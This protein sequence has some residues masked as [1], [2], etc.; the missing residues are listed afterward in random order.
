MSYTTQQL[1]RRYIKSLLLEFQTDEDDYR[2]VS[3]S[4]LQ[5]QLPTE[6]N[7][8]KYN[9]LMYT[10]DVDFCSENLDNILDTMIGNKDRQQVIRWMRRLEGDSNKILIQL[11]YDK[12][13]S[14]A[15][16]HFMDATKGTLGT[17]LA[18][19][20]DLKPGSAVY[21]TL[22]SFYTAP[23]VF[24]RQ[25][26]IANIKTIDELQDTILIN[27]DLTYWVVSDCKNPALY[28]VVKRMFS[29][30]GGSEL[31]TGLAAA[32]QIST[33]LPIAFRDVGKNIAELPPKEQ[34]EVLN[35]LNL[36]TSVFGL[37]EIGAAV[38]ASGAGVVGAAPA[39]GIL[40]GIAAVAGAASVGPM[41]VLGSYY[42]AAR[43]NETL[44]GMPAWLTYYI[45]AGLGAV[46]T[47]FRAAAY[48]K[49]GKE[50]SEIAVLSNNFS[51]I[52]NASGLE[53]IGVISADAAKRLDSGA[54]IGKN[55]GTLKDLFEFC[56]KFPEL[57]SLTSGKFVSTTDG[58][59]WMSTAGKTL[60]NPDTGKAIVFSSDV[61]DFILYASKNRPVL[62]KYMTWY[63]GMPGKIGKLFA[64]AGALFDAYAVKVA[65][66]DTMSVDPQITEELP[67][68]QDTSAFQI[69]SGQA[70][71]SLVGDIYS[72]ILKIQ[73]NIAALASN[74]SKTAT[75]FDYKNNRK[76]SVDMSRLGTI[77]ED[78]FKSKP[79]N[80][81]NPYL[82]FD[83]ENCRL[84]IVDPLVFG[85]MDHLL[86]YPQTIKKAA[87]ARR[88]FCVKFNKDIFGLLVINS[89]TD[90]ANVD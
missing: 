19:T 21:K 27:P 74:S 88:L 28:G 48:V 66:S 40:G 67:V 20:Y 49:S 65:I 11:G 34:E 36:A 32:F 57:G 68:N 8:S 63:S 58:F 80:S 90:L 13:L 51:S 56:K 62:M 45:F 54:K 53:E 37:T 47:Y 25:L 78:N 42:K 10:E 61:K 59:T 72:S 6:R 86:K 35:G 52:R 1:L 87:D 69:V 79:E 4:D 43:P 73:P 84:L 30:I 7:F 85:Q 75:V 82:N 50:I 44:F 89:V 55:S 15:F 70:G 77:L 29:G 12:S 83:P 23:Q 46:G 76:M 64:G 9:A 38:G 3:P 17:K 2:R 16:S 41:L 81:Q 14:D 5:N 31:E 71:G 24:D 18:S 33:K 60:T 22:K 39:A 26:K